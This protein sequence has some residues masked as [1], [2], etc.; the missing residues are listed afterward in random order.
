MLQD[1]TSYHCFHVMHGACYH[2]FAPGP[3]EYWMPHW[4]MDALASA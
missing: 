2:L 3:M 1:L 4:A